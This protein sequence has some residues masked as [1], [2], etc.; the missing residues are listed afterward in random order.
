[1]DE[2]SLLFSAMYNDLLHASGH[3]P[4][5]KT[6]EQITFALSHTRLYLYE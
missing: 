2:I 4:A 6:E 3:Y 5:D 1:M